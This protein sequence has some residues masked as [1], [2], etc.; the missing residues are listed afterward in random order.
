MTLQSVSGFD[1]DDYNHHLVTSVSVI[2]GVNARDVD[3]VA[4]KFV[5]LV[6]YKFVESV[7]DA[8]LVKAVAAN[9]VIAES[10]V[11]V[12]VAPVGRVAAVEIATYDA[13]NVF[14]L[15]EVANNTAALATKLSEV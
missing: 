13:S 2:T 14:A 7:T 11:K 10:G 1:A 15:A 9:A 12:H 6:T 4:V 5:V 8:Q 3:V